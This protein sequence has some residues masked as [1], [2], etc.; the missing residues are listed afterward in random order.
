MIVTNLRSSSINTFRSCPMAWFLEYNLG[1][2][3]GVNKAAIKGTIVHNVLELLALL[4]KADQEGKTYIKSSNSQLHTKDYLQTNK[5]LDKLTKKIY[6]LHTKKYDLNW[7]DQDQKDCIKWVR[8]TLVSWDGK[9]DPRERNII[10]PEMFFDIEIIKPWS[11][12]KYEL[13]NGKILQG[14]LK[15]RG[16]IDLICN[17]DNTIEILDW[18]TGK[19]LDWATSTPKTTESLKDDIQVRMYH[20]IVSK[21]YPNHQIIITMVYINNV[22]PISIYLNDDDIS[23]TEKI[24]KNHFQTMRDSSPICKKSWKCGRFCEYNKSD[25]SNTTVTPIK[26]DKILSKCEQISY[27]LQYRDEQQ[28]ITNMTNGNIFNNLEKYNQG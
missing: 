23:K 10:E 20:Y 8:K 19:F 26:H 5:S 21:L 1:W 28:V 16:T 13:S 4:K 27:I 24:L 17:M 22:G 9:F 25:F 2:D 14:F 18:K 12:Y 7:V 15:L 11:A 6:K 3:S